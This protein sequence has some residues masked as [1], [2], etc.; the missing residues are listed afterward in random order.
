[1]CEGGL[2]PSLPERQ[3]GG[4]AA[5]SMASLVLLKGVTKMPQISLLQDLRRSTKADPE[6]I[7]MEAKRS[8]QQKPCMKHSLLLIHPQGMCLCGSRMLTWHGSSAQS[9]TQYW[10][11]QAAYLAQQE[12]ECKSWQWDREQWGETG[13]QPPGERRDNGPMR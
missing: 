9:L 4:H 12:R 2:P 3:L 7:M 13:A 1:M 8:S 5:T 11:A 10:E 6:A